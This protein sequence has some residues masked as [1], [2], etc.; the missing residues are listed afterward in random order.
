MLPHYHVPVNCEEE[1]FCENP[2]CFIYC[3]NRSGSGSR[4]LL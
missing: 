4:S 2:Q 3:K 1:Q